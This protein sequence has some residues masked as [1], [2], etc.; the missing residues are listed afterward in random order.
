M[1]IFFNLGT[2]FIYFTFPRTWF[3]MAIAWG[4]ERVGQALKIMQKKYG[5]YAE[6]SWGFTRSKVNKIFFGHARSLKLCAVEI[7]S[8]YPARQF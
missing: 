3:G 1:L 5:S 8:C 2:S 6:S 4:K 7:Q